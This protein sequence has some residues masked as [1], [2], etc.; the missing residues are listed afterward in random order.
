MGLFQIGQCS[1]LGDRFDDLWREKGQPD[2][3]GYVAVDN[4]APQKQLR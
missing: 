3:M 4:S 2:Q 1:T